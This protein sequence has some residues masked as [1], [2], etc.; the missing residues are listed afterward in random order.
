MAAALKPRANDLTGRRFGRLVVVAFAERRQ[1]PGGTRVLWLCKCDCGG[2]TKA[3]A[4]TLK[5]GHTQ[6]CGCF[7]LSRISE[8]LTKHGASKAAEYPAWHRAKRRCSDPSVTEY[9]SYGGRGIK[10][11]ER[12]LND[13][14]AFLSDMG[15]RPTAQHTI[16]RI[17]N[18]GNYEPHNCRWATRL[19]Q[20]NNKRNNVH[21]TIDGRTLTVSQWSRETGVKARTIAKRISKGWAPER[22]ILTPG[23]VR[24]RARMPGPPLLP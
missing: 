18:D 24:D 16:E 23:G 15:P 11:C 21:L 8:V 17:N 5:R 14:G 1:S 2:E 20:G 7:R 9:E 13:F 12:W 22:A 10:M 4:N 3:S 19:E 6:S